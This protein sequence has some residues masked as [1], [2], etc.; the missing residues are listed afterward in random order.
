MDAFC[1]DC[2]AAS[3]QLAVKAERIGRTV[4]DDTNSSRLDM[5]WLA[6]AVAATQP[7]I[8]GGIAAD[9]VVHRTLAFLTAWV[10]LLAEA[11][12]ILEEAWGAFALPVQK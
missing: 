3:G 12:R 2:H 4:A 11:H 8:I 10:A 7:P 1:A 9:T 6:V 5:A